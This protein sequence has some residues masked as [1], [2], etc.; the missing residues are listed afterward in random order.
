MDRQIM[1]RDAC[2]NK[3]HK[4]ERRQMKRQKKVHV[5]GEHWVYTQST[6]D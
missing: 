1:G 4:E 6:E 3:Q 5:T 2:R